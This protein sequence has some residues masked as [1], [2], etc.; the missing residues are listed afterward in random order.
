MED[1]KVEVGQEVVVFGA[2]ASIWE[3]D[4]GETIT[5]W[6]PYGSDDCTC[7]L[8]IN[9]SF[10]CPAMEVTKGLVSSTSAGFDAYF[11]IGGE[12]SIGTNNIN[13]AQ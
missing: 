4:I 2:S 13:T 11:L 5:Y 10:D 9:P 12:F 7:A 8:Q 3:A 6:H 1:G